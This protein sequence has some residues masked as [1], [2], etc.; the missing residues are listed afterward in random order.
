[1]IFVE[2]A[3]CGCPGLVIRRLLDDNLVDVIPLLVDLGVEVGAV[4][5]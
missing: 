5:A 3:I 2:I 4:W 1:M